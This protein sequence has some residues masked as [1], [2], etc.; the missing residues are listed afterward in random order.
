[1]KTLKQERRWAG[2]YVLVGLLVLGGCKAEEKAPVPS[3]EAVSEATFDIQ[4]KV[5]SDYSAWEETGKEVAAARAY[6]V[7]NPKAAD[8][9]KV[10]GT[11]ARVTL[12]AAVVSVLSGGESAVKNL[13]LEVET[14]KA[15]EAA[16]SSLVTLM[17]DRL[18]VENRDDILA[19][20]K[21]LQVAGP[22]RVK[23]LEEIVAKNGVF[24]SRARALLMKE[25]QPVIAELVGAEASTLQLETVQQELNKAVALLEVPH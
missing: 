3:K 11:A 14:G 12:D 16:A 5:F 20:A 21:V 24:T 25:I 8:A 15:G 18:A 4:S 23:G 22:E 7:Q 9:A 13:G 2:L 1:M 17:T 10:A 6:L 19:F